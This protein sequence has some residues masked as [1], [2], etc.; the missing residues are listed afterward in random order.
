M[1]FSISLARW[2]LGMLPAWEQGS[3]HGNG[4]RP[5]KM[6]PEELGNA[7]GEQVLLMGGP[8]CPCW[9]HPDCRCSALSAL[10][11][12]VTLQEMHSAFLAPFSVLPNSSRLGAVALSRSS[13]G[14]I[15]I[16]HQQSSVQCHLQGGNSTEVILEAIPWLSCPCWDW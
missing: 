12:S 2:D 3:G 6:F 13:H 11:L 7:H 1:S 4:D 16:F 8:G 14:R 9:Q 15:C 10:I 5:M